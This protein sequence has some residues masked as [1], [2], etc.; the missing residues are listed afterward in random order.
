ML[1]GVRSILLSYW[2]MMQLAHCLLSDNTVLAHSFSIVA[3]RRETV[4]EKPVTAPSI[5][6]HCPSVQNR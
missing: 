5:P 1:G 2:R 4:N 3:Y 6:L